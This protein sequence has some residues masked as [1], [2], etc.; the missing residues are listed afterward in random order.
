MVTCKNAVCRFFQC[1]S[2]RTAVHFAVMLELIAIV[3]LAAMGS[4]QH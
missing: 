1:E 4:I 2:G 3:C